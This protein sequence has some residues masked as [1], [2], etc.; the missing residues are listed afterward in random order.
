MNGKIFFVCMTLLFGFSSL[1]QGQG[2]DE[3]TD[4]ER[5]KKDRRPF[6]DATYGIGFPEQIRFEGEFSDIGLTE[7]KIGYSKIKQY[8]NYVYSL[9]ESFLY[10]S[11]LA[12]DLY[13]SDQDTLGKV[14]TE[15]I[16]FGFAN[17]LGYGYHI[18]AFDILPYNERSLVWTKVTTTRPG[19]L[20]Q[21]DIDI[22]NRY[23]NDFRF[24]ELTEGGVKFNMF[25]FLSLTGAYE[26]QVVYPRHLFWK[27]LGSI[28]IRDAGVAAI[29]VFSE[30][31]LDRTAFLGP[32]L[33]FVLK[34]GLTYAFYNAM[35][36]NMNW[37]FE[38]EAPLTFANFKVGVSITF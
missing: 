6:L 24:G 17:R 10:G 36:Y 18:G 33:Y 26:L 3:E 15:T 29:T 20:I 1:L 4:W 22:L 28:L 21:T 5:W 38:T 12:T 14:N 19:N 23:E 35:R 7:A 27:W 34:N 13:F 16:R 2:D 31:I 9:D 37:P 8:K 32:I 11:Y 25:R 30:D